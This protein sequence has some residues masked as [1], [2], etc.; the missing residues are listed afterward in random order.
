MHRTGS[1]RK[2]TSPHSHSPSVTAVAAVI[3]ANIALA[4][5]PMLVRMA[6]VGPVAAA[7]WR[8]AM[9]VPVLFM[10]A[11]ATGSNPV[12]DSRGLWF[13][14]A[15]G[16]VA[17][18]GDLA[19]WHTGIVRTTL[20]NATLFGNS[21]TLIYPIYGFL[22]ARMWPTR[23]QAV[24]LALAAG[25]AALLMGRS[26]ELSARNLA[27]DLF[28]LLAGV[29]YAVYFICMARARMRLAPAPA[30]AMISLATLAPLLVLSLAL[31][32]R[33][34]P[35]DW[36][37]LVILTLSSQLLGQ[38]L[39]SY[40]LGHLPPILIGIALLLQPIVAGITGWIVYDERLTGADWI[41]ALLV[42]AALVLV[43]RGPPPARLAA[44][45][46]ADDD[47]ATKSDGKGD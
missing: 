43:R 35:I 27:G 42:A 46:L 34:V 41:G 25:G 16:G 38:G 37:P 4:F 28:C 22:I 7:F 21:A 3:V 15:L 8:L 17:F 47:D 12:R 45:A 13:V 26:A 2:S 29:L 19:S 14:I 30:L 1:E 24:A 10:V 9:A 18:A 5:G 20:A 6:D 32:E 44:E 39:M 40:A 36:V 11:F 23:W 33:F 31:G